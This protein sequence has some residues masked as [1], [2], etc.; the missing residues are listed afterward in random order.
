MKVG[1]R[2]SPLRS[3]RRRR[4]WLN[5]CQR[6]EVAIFRQTPAN[7][8]QRRLQLLE[9]F[10]FA[11]KFP[12]SRTFWAPNFVFWKKIFRRAKIYGVGRKL[13]P[14]FCPCLPRRQHDTTWTSNGT[15]RVDGP[16]SSR[17]RSRRWQ[18][19][20]SQ[21]TEDRRPSSRPSWGCTA[22]GTTGLRTLDLT[23]THTDTLALTQAV[24]LN[25]IPGEF[26]TPSL[27][28]RPRPRPR[29]CG[30]DRGQNYEA[31]ASCSRSRP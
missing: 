15:A 6:Q 22:S 29:V 16:S 27:R 28:P 23:H 5:S 31:K 2:H 10:N 13:S 21:A 24:M 26:L 11:L 25:E 14:C 20:R 8:Q 19:R 12:Q 1:G 18:K 3:C 4:R 30:Q 17:L 9:N 7:F